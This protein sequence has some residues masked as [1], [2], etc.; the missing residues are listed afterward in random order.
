MIFTTTLVAGAVVIDIERIEDDRGFFARSWCER[1]FM[2]HGLNPRVAQVNIGRSTRKGTIRGLHYQLSPWQEAKTVRCT[3]GAV[4]DVVV[5]LRAESP[6]YRRWFGVEL[7][8]DNHRMLYVP[9]GCAQGYQTL[10]DNTE[11]C[12]HTSQRYA[13][14]SARGVRYDDPAFGITWPLAVTNISQADLSWPDFAGVPRA[15]VAE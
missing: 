1:E 9:E 10:V 4:Y 6:T 7:T 2:A 3:Q 5:D 14:E 11:I 15:L 13:P 8:G 12:Y